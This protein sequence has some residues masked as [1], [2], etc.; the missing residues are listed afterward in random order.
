MQMHG[1]MH[2][3][4]DALQAL[5]FVKV[6]Q[7]EHGFGK[8]ARLSSLAALFISNQRALKMGM[9]VKGP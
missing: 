6:P 2:E 7:H 3:D 1:T 8:G 4:H 9:R 5:D